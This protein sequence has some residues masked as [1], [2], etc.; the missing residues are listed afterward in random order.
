MNFT[1]FIRNTTEFCELELLIPEFDYKRKYGISNLK[2]FQ[3]LREC[4]FLLK[5]SSVK[6]I[7]DIQNN[8]ISTRASKTVDQVNGLLDELASTCK[9]STL[10]TLTSS[11][12]KLEILRDL[13]QV[14]YNV[15]ERD[16]MGQK[17]NS[18]LELF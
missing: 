4:G 8:F 15:K 10:K 3:L 14:F 2:L 18:W 5:N 1:E 11:R 12:S 17:L 16:W 13:F 9:Y 7:Q 6:S